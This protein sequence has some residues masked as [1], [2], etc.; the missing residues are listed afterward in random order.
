MGYILSIEQTELFP[1][2]STIKT[3]NST[4]YILD[5]IHTGRLDPYTATKMEYNKQIVLLNS[6]LPTCRG[7]ATGT[8]TDTI[9]DLN[10]SIYLIYDYKNG[11]LHGLHTW[12]RTD[13]TISYLSCHQ[14]G[15]QTDSLLPTC[16]GFATGTGT[17]TIRD[18]RDSIYLIYVYQNGHLHGVYT[19]Y[20]TDGTISYTYNYQNGQ[21]HG[22]YTQYD[23]NGR[24]SSYSLA[25]YQN[26]VRQANRLLDS[27]LPTCRG[28]ST[29]TGTD[30]IR[31]LRDSIYLI[32]GYKNGQQHGLY[33]KYDT[34]YNTDGTI[35]S[36]SC[37]QNGQ[38][39]YGLLPTC[40]GFST[41]T[42][43]D[44][45]RDLRNSIYLIYEYQNGQLHG[46][47]T[48]YNT[49][50]TIYYTAQLS[51]RP[52]TRVRNCIQYRQDDSLLKLLPKW[53]VEETHIHIQQFQQFY[54]PIGSR[55]ESREYPTFLLLFC[56]L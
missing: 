40:R 29:G 5:T 34:S 30:T 24:I 19:Q 56:L 16:R 39:N 6:L 47:Y 46:L 35:L 20:R 53:G 4:G 28:F 27:L 32:Y 26:G 22:V 7:F 49:D 36:L 15:V 54:L 42:G 17:D 2:Q 1:T 18:L 25:C 3:D 48:Y 13:G 31:D 12:Y 51:K 41:G 9:R 11:Q 33:T 10:D 55:I 14:N 52:K 21:L 45:I 44:T 43:T 23:T 50:G 38:S 37:Y 8:G